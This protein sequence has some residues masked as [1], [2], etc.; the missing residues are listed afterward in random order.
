MAVG[1]ATGQG[2]KPP[3]WLASL[4]AGSCVL[5]CV[6]LLLAGVGWA[7]SVLSDEPAP[8][9]VK[10]K[11]IESDDDEEDDSTGGQSK[12]PYDDEHRRRG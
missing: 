8:A 12:T 3:Q 5:F 7:R 11:P 1:A 2:I 4:G 10:K 6:G 9:P